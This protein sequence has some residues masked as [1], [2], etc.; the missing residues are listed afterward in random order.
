MKRSYPPAN[1]SARKGWDTCLDLPPNRRKSELRR[2]V[3]MMDDPGN[4]EWASGWMDAW[5]TFGTSTWQEIKKRWDGKG[6]IKAAGDDMELRE[7]VIK[8]ARENPELR[9]HLVPIL[10][11]TA[12]CACD[13]GVEAGR[14]HGEPGK[15][16]GMTG[17]DVR[18]KGKWTPE[19][20]GKCFY[21]TGDEADR[22]YVTQHGGPGGQS[23]GKPTRTWREYEKQRWK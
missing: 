19:A 20:K 16:Y 11:K 22:C 13:D 4:R 8:L 14:E 1:A 18:G 12:E 15:G 7:Q 6:R 10:R 2:V 9:K 17:P 21:E 3:K 5:E 23:K